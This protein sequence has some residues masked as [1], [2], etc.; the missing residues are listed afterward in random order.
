MRSLQ[1]LICYP[2]T[3]IRW[4]G[5]QMEIFAQFSCF[6]DVSSEKK[7]KVQICLDIKSMQ[8]S[9]WAQIFLITFFKTKWSELFKNVCTV[10]LYSVFLVLFLLRSFRR[11]INERRGWNLKRSNQYWK[12]CHIYSPPNLYEFLCS[13]E[14]FIIL[15]YN[16]E[17]QAL[18]TW[19]QIMAHNDP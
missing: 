15:Y 16:T 10:A 9:K 2:Q 12:F 7:K 8:V 17:C 4:N 14:C 13:L 18:F 1:Y 5:E 11:N 19:L 3:S 6:S